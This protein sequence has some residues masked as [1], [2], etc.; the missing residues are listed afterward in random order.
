MPSSAK[1]QRKTIHILGVPMDLG[2]GR[3]GVDM[4]PSAIRIA[5]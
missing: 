4:G 3:R 5:G 1:T 2:S